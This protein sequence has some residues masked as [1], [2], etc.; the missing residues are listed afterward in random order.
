MAEID[1]TLGLVLGVS[2]YPAYYETGPTVVSNTAIGL[3]LG[4]NS[5]PQSGAPPSAQVIP[6]SLGMLLGLKAA[7]VCAIP[8]PVIIPGTL[9]L[10]LGI[11]A[12]LATAGFVQ[13]ASP[14]TA[15]PPVGIEIPGTLSLI[16][17][18]HA[19]LVSNLIEAVEIPGGLGLLLGLSLVEWNEDCE[20]WVLTGNL[21]NPAPMPITNL[22]ALR[23]LGVHT[24]GQ[25]MTACIYWRGRIITG[26]RLSR[27]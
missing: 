23:S 19:G 11:S 18:L 27:G 14:D 8:P 20:T 15:P 2:L 21:F 22:I 17:G 16:L 24:T 1:G 13:T 12:D 4:I 25:R 9:G 7:P 26:L 10:L 6:G 5:A 3:V